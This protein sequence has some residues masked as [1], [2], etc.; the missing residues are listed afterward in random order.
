MLRIFCISKTPLCDVIVGL[1][2][3]VTPHNQRNIMT[4]NNCRLHCTRKAISNVWNIDFIHGHIHGLSCKKAWYVKNS[5]RQS[6]PYVSCVCGARKIT[7]RKYILICSIYDENKLYIVQSV[8]DDF[9]AGADE[10]FPVHHLRNKTQRL[11]LHSLRTQFLHAV[12]LPNVRNKQLMS[13]VPQQRHKGAVY[14]RL[15]LRYS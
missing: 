14:F 13:R 8:Y 1:F 2:C 4:S 9:F 5:C 11:F 12:R 15:S 3:D 7:R 6:L 10:G